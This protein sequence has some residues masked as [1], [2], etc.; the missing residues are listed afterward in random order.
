M[1][2]LL[3]QQAHARQRF[4]ERFGMWIGDITLAHVVRAIQ[5]GRSR[6][7]C[8]KSKRI[9]FHEVDVGSTRAIAVYD[10]DRKSVASFMRPERCWEAG[11]EAQ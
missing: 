7:V 11:R 4:F 3:S 10:K 8:R 2:K 9:T 5:E 6:P 1:T